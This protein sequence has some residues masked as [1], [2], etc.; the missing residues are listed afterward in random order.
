MSSCPV[1]DQ[2]EN[3]DADQEYGGDT[4]NR[5]VHSESPGHQSHEESDDHKVKHREYFFGWYSRIL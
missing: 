5:V 3:D 2:S 4:Q 1:N